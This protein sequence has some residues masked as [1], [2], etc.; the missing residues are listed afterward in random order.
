VR[1]D[2]AGSAVP[3]SGGVPVKLSPTVISLL[4]AVATAAWP[5][6][7]S[8]AAVPDEPGSDQ[9]VITAERVEAEEGPP[10]RIVWL[11]ENVTVTH[12]GA[13]LR[14]AHGIYYETEGHVILVGNVTGEDEGRAIACDTLDYFLDTEIAHLRGNA[15]YSDTSA[16]T[17]AD[18]I[19]MLRG[20]NVVVCRGN[21]RSRDSG[22]TSE[23]LA[24]SLVYD[25]DTGEGRASRGPV[26]KTYD[27]EGAQ[28][29]TLT[30]DVIE[31]STVDDA[32]RAFGDVTI[33]REDITALA[34]AASLSRGGSI[35]L[36][37]DP[38]VQQG[39]DQL[40]GNRIRVSTRDGEVSRVVSTGNAR[41]TYHIEP[42]EP[43]GDWSHGVVRGDTLTMFMEEGQPVLTTVRG[44][45]ESEHLVGESGE[46]NFIT[47][48]TIDVL[49]T[50]SLVKRVAFRGQAS[51]TYSFPPEGLA[52]V[53]PGAP[54]DSDT[55]IGPPAP[56]AP[57]TFDTVAYQSNEINY[58]VARNRIVLT[59]AARIDHQ[60][61]V[62][63][64]EDIIFDPDEQILEAS[65]NPDL[66]EKEDRLVGAHL[67]YDLEGKTGTID[68]GVTTFE[69]GLYYGDHIVREQDGALKV[70][71]G[72]YTTCSDPNPHYRLVSHRMKIYMDDKVVAKPIIL[73]IGEIPVLA[74][75]F[76]V[77][78]IRKERHSGF[79]LPQ[80]ELGITE[81][82][83]KF[84]R[85]F[86][87]Y[88]A[89]SDYWDASVWADYYEL[90]RWIGHVE[91]RY[92]RRYM[93]SGSVEASFM[94][95]LVYNKRRWDLKFSHRQE[96]GRVWTAGASGDF[97]SDATYASDSNQSIQESLNRS[98]R[99]QLWVRGR[100]SR[101]S[102]GVTVDR[103]EQLDAETIDELLPKVDV[104][105]T[106]QP[107]VGPDQ[108]LPGYASWLKRI[109]FGWSARAVND[110]DKAGDETVVRQGVGVKGSLKGTGKYLGWLSLSPRLNFRQDW[111]DRDKEGTEF[112]GR[113]TYDAGLSARTTVYG[114][115]FPGVA[116][117]SALRHIVEP[118]ASFSWTPE[119][120]QY[121]DENGQDRF[122]RFSGF[123]STPR[124]KK[125]VGLSLVNKLQAKL[126]S[127]ESERKVDNLLRLSTSTSYD[128]KKD[129]R[130]W[131]DLV[132]GLEVRPGPAVSMR[133]NA[134]HDAYDGAIENST[135]TATVNL[136][137]QPS[138]VS[139]E[140]WEDRVAQTD[141][142]A[143]Q[144]RRE[145]EAG[146]MG[147]L[148]GD[149]AWDGSLTFRYSRGADP[150]NA[151]YWIDGGLAFSP[152]E[153]WRL[154]YSLHYDLDEGEV[155]SQ[156]YTIYRDLHCWEAQFT[157]RYYDGEWQYY[158]RISVKALPEIKA[159]S[160]QRF[161]ARSVR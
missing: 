15:S 112:P 51:G 152:S 60:T 115:F 39:E 3:E 19:L 100:W 143:D 104:T 103:R 142:P 31:F 108:E 71:H 95:E 122:Y 5:V 159:E 82:E 59:G 118:S 74:L 56:A 121:F 132:T 83:G 116:G 7:P 20:E 52:P 120:L 113:F 35:V 150:T 62:L 92:K 139:A 28:D 17:T 58:Y 125:S 129:D 131:S 138:A 46:R 1:R 102:L 63:L 94:Q 85:N 32:I 33:E 155:A 26:L 145:L 126:G 10:G 135:V 30:A 38:F 96:M 77:F 134:R 43:E 2:S 47:S 75:P 119:F 105:A 91:T 101:Y 148:P 23:L 50:E 156:E 154:N 44:H 128:L 37:G 136:S 107:I 68:G 40:T 109:S 45:A 11:E 144:L 123:G 90:T 54:A 78:P 98:L 153:R 24:G 81:G 13:T 16:T 72:T 4:I 27:D 133:W 149:R 69:D 157:Q 79:L 49:F 93:L 64:A 66:R 87:Y 110:R 53:E 6:V 8:L 141:S 22:G 55:L 80:L 97:R 106:Q 73:Y 146:S 9:F 14:G 88:W 84:V 25:F 70:S 117:L 124:S 137:G 111:Y 140:P 114:T 41:A 61:T 76:Y 99:S 57:I 34:S 86:G 127:G 130:P 65:G 42:D 161:I 29:G 89:P 12:L 18:R 147:S 151:S 160:G 21:V 36:V 67:S 158:F 48:R